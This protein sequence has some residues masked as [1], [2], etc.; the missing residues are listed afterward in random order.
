M[1]G[2]IFTPAWPLECSGHSKN[3][4]GVWQLRHVCAASPPQRGSLSAICSC[5]LIAHVSDPRGPKCR[6][7]VL[8]HCPRLPDAE[9]AKLDEVDRE[10]RRSAQRASH[11]HHLAVAP[12]RTASGK[13][14][15]HVRT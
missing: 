14:T 1:Q 5:R 6:D 10:L 13:V 9:V 3:A 11:S 7:W 12:A 4:D 15:G 8:S 2:A